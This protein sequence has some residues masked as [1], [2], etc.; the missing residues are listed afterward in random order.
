MEFRF[1]WEHVNKPAGTNSVKDFRVS[2][3]DTMQKKKKKKA[4][5]Y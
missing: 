1:Q 3:L 2:R 4:P 5:D